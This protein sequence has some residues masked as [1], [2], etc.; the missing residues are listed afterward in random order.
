MSAQ[1]D[2]HTFTRYHTSTLHCTYGSSA[3][4]LRFNKKIVTDTE[5]RQNNGKTRGFV[6]ACGWVV[7][8]SY[9]TISLEKNFSSEVTNRWDTL[10]I[11]IHLYRIAQN[12]ITYLVKCKLKYVGNIFILTGFR[13]IFWN[14]TLHVQCKTHSSMIPL[15]KFAGKFQLIRE[16]ILG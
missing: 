16:N 7:M 2:S 12:S 11:I 13:N 1:S 9:L 4:S 10:E 14:N 3:L 6:T 5:H 8:S 15:C